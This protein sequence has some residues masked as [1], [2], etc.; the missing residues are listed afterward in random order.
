[1]NTTNL[2]NLLEQFSCRP[3]RGLTH[4]R[5]EKLYEM[6]LNF[7]LEHDEELSDEIHSLLEKTIESVARELERQDKELPGLSQQLIENPASVEL[8]L[9]Q[10]TLEELLE[11]EKRGINLKPLALRQQFANMI[12]RCLQNLCIH[13]NFMC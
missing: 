8:I 2:Y 7:L 6:L 4:Q 10:M 3:L 12:L 9:S 11:A 1:M 5:L 13:S